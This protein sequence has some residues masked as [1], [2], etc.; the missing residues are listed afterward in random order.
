MTSPDDIVDRLARLPLLE[1]VPRAELEWLAARGEV[2]RYPAGTMLRPVGAAIEE[3]YIV[4]TG[5]V[6]WHLERRGGWRKAGD[7]GPG[8]IVGPIPYSRIDKVPGNVVI[9]DDVTAFVLHRTQ[10]PALISECPA[11]TAALVHHML[12]RSREIRTAELN[13]DRLQ[14][15]GRI[16]SGLAHELN[17]PASAAR[18]NAQSLAALLDDTEQAARELAA[19][20]L[21]DAQLEA[22]DAIRTICE[23]P[24]PAQSALQA[25]DREDDVAEW[26][27]RHALDPVLADPLAASVVSIDALELLARELPPA[28]VGA[29]LRW[30]A[31]GITTRRVAGEIASATGRIHELIG[32]VKG[33]TFM[34]RDA[35]PEDVDVAR[36]LADTLTVLES[37][38]RS[39]AVTAHLETAAD[40]PRVYGFG[41]E[42]NQVWQNLIDNAI[43]AAGSEGH[44]MITATARRDSI[45]VRVADD[46]PGI[47]EAHRTRVFDPFFT[48]KPVGQGS[49]L[50]LDLV[51]RVVHL[52]NG[53]VDFT[54]QPGR[55][56]FRVRLP[57]TG[58]RVHGLAG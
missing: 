50:G 43:D 13:D 53:D 18:R 22:V 36:G 12:D 35:V 49:G 7:V 57:V 5:R 26:L 37:K 56:T 6:A 48:T 8:R 9:E 2:R 32:A 10:F 1:A 19:A 38:L 40:L 39:K 33:F 29:V 21:T 31:G 45:V 23:G 25:A 44:V 28:A 24:A 11:L 16:A 3:M 51:R 27:S 34:D 4:L 20:R 41:S 52:H 42:I 14:S 46:G 54:T 47:P 15:I 55:T 17:N 58:A 30:V